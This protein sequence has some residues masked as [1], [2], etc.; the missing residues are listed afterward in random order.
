[1]DLVDTVDTV[2][3]VDTVD[4]PSTPLVGVSKA[5]AA[6]IASESEA[7]QRPPGPPCPPS[8]PNPNPNP[9]PIHVHTMKGNIMNED[10]SL[11]PSTAA[12]LPPSA[13]PAAEAAPPLPSGPVEPVAAP[14]APAEP[15]PAD[16]SVPAA[17]HPE[18]RALAEALAGELRQSAYVQSVDTSLNAARARYGDA[19]DEAFSAL[20][21]S[22]NADLARVVLAGGDPGET[23]MRLYAGARQTLPPPSIIRAPGGAAA[24][25]EPV[26]ESAVAYAFGA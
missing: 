5:S 19:F 20:I 26:P 21:G 4:N 10:T 14:P 8:P 16:P 24:L 9:N 22:G 23:L 18:A 11:T 7:I 3:L 2:D 13:A 12:A 17:P 15:P 1:M 25:G 6:V